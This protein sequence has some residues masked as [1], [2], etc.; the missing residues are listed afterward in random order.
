MTLVTKMKKSQEVTRTKSDMASTSSKNVHFG[1]AKGA[2]KSREKFLAENNEIVK[3]LQT[4]KL[5]VRK[6]A[7]LYNVSNDTVL[8]VKFEKYGL[9]GCFKSCKYTVHLRDS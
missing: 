6:T 2:V 1:R 8:K 5:S 3:S 4:E 9:P 7:K